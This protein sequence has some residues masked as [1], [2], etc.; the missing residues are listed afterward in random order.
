ML[1][2]V[3]FGAYLFLMAALFAYICWAGRHPRERR[4]GEEREPERGGASVAA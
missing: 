4:D 3:I 1:P 2:A